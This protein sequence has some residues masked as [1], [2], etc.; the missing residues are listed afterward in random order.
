MSVTHK[1]IKT[2]HYTFNVRIKP[3]YVR[4]VLFKYYIDIGDS[5]KP[6]LS[7]IIFTEEAAN[8]IQDGLEKVAKLSNIDALYD[9]VIDQTKEDFSKHSFGK[10]LLQWVIGYIKSE[11]KQVI[12]LQLDDESYIPC[13]R[14]P[15]ETVDLLTYSIALNKK[16]WY[17]LNFNAFIEK[18]DIYNKYKS[19]VNTYSL[20]STKSSSSWELFFLKNVTSMYA[21]N[22]ILENEDLY[23]R[24]YEE[25]STFPEFFK[26]LAETIGRDDKC[27]FFKGWL[28]EFISSYIVI[29]RRWTIR[30]KSEGGYNKSRRKTFARKS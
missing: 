3:D 28:Q 26:K 16:T 6:C 11:H 30:L 10:E 13:N 12:Y 7:L 20:V 14:K 15:I 5:N 22:K 1:T 23:K 18:K 19:E 24:I 8:M 17:E 21:R 29:S 25:S 4:E 2:E 9:C 27:K